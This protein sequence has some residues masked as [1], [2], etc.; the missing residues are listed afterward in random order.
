MAGF[1]KSNWKQ[2]WEAKNPIL[3]DGERGYE[4]D[5]GKVK[6]GN[7]TSRW[8]DLPYVVGASGFLVPGDRVP[9]L[10]SDFSKV[11]ETGKYS[12]LID[13]PTIPTAASL[14]ASPE[15][16]E[17][18]AP[19]N[20]GKLIVREYTAN[21][22]GIP[23][24]IG[25]AGCW[26]TLVGGGGGGGSG[27]RGA[28]ATVRSGGGGGGGGGIQ[29][30]VWV[31]AELL[32]STYAINIATPGVGGAAITADNANGNPGTSGGITSFV[33]GA[34]S[35][36]ATSGN[37]AAGGQISA[38]ATGGS[39]GGGWPN[40]ATGGASSGS[41]GAGSASSDNYNGQGVGGGAGGGISAADVAASGGNGGQSVAYAVPVTVAGVVDGS[42]P[43]GG[44]ITTKGVIGSGAAGGAAS[45]TKAAQDGATALGFGAGG[46]GGGASLNGNNSGKGGNGAPGYARVIWAFLA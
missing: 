42:L 32:G 46:G 31:P 33:S 38:A 2:I 29:P 8:N 44:V 9:S 12:D 20:Q 7:G 11:A 22:S 18:F 23:V 35:L 16:T 14:A 10:A 34:Y 19:I 4:Y 45:I 39:G 28:A 24:P 3:R 25:V 13:E 26:L 1:T 43:S 41:G 15:F 17:A 6:I 27:R 21:D 5:S 37:G 30:G 40:G 36:R